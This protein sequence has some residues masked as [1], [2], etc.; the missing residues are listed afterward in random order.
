MTENNLIKKNN[1]VSDIKKQGKRPD[2]FSL[3][4]NL[5]SFA[6]ERARDIVSRR[7]GLNQEKKE[8]LE[9][10]GLRYGVTRERIRQIISDTMKS[11]SGKMENIDFKEIEE[12]LIFTIEENGGIIK[13]TEVANALG[14]RLSQEINSVRFVAECSK[15]IKL[16]EEKGIIAHSWL[17]SETVLDKVK[18]INQ[19]VQ[20]LLEA[21]KKLL[22]DEEISDKLSL[23]IP[24][25]DQKQ[26]LNWLKVLTKVKKNQFGR[27]GLAHWEEINPR[28]TREK[29]YLVLKESG[30]PLHFSQIAAVI[31]KYKLGKRKAH[32]QTVHNELIKD[33]RFVLVGRGIYALAKWG[34][35]KGTIREVIKKIL[36]ESE[37]PLSKDE[38]LFRVLKIRQV[39]PSTVIIN[40]NNSQFFEKREGL[41]RMRK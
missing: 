17:S 27:W 28:G 38:I 15:R 32:P 14:L 39:K 13:E 19:E 37:R 26:I 3:V 16:V 34:Y 40:L 23:K 36:A 29:V 1:P 24:E 10:I 9:K 7:F 33:E 6:P 12:H 11:V 5:L 21:E 20:S 30:K 35:S 8:T 25:F 41:Y 22:T 18:S 4:K 31:D 2:F